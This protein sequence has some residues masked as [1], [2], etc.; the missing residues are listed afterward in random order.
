MFKKD[1][2]L[3]DLAERCHLLAAFALALLH[4]GLL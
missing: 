2:S 3:L 1:D 4:D